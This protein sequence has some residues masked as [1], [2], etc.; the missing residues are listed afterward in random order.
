MTGGKEE[1]RGERDKRRE[2]GGGG[3]YY[4]DDLY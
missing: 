2:E 3:G 1:G 4:A